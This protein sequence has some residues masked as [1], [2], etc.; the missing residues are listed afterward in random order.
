MLFLSSVPNGRAEFCVIS[1]R[2][3][4]VLCYQYTCKR[5]FCFIST[6][7]KKS[8]LLSVHV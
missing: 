4:T 3:K 1:T 7:V 6:R 8:F 2:V 5:E